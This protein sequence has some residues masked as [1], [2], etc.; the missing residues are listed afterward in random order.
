M[1]L[2]KTKFD[3]LRNNKLYQQ[4]KRFYC[5]PRTQLYDGVFKLQVDL[6]PS[7][8]SIPIWDWHFA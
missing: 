5:A 8:D 4:W 6:E 3:A 1:L 7:D 2:N